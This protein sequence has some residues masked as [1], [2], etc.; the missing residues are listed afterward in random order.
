MVNTDKT[1]LMTFGSPTRLKSIPEFEI[2]FK[3]LPLQ[4]VSSYKYLGITLDNKLNYDKHV[5]RLI[6]QVSGKLK[7]F[8]RMRSF[9]NN[10]AAMLVYKNMI[11]PVI[12]Y[13]DILLSACSFE[14]KRRLQVLQNKGLRCAL[15]KSKDEFTSTDDLH[16]DAQLLK[17]CYRR[18]EHTLNLMYDLSLDNEHVKVAQHGIK[19]RSHSKKLL[20]VKRPKTEKFRKSLAYKGPAKWNSLSADFHHLPTKNMFKVQIKTKIAKGAISKLNASGQETSFCF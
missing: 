1:K 20:K 7:Q 16:S 6:S 5:Q 10:S 18:E 15:N 8:K 4:A 3:N 9:L 17:L 19:T 13:G 11:L 2:C 14:N 12:E